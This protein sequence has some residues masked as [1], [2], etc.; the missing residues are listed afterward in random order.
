MICRS[1]ARPRHRRE[2]PAVATVGYLNSQPHALPPS[3]E[4]TFGFVV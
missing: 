3:A 2:G 1:A 4:S